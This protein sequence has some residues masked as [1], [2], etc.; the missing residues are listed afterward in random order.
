RRIHVALRRET[1]VTIARTGPYDPQSI[2][3]QGPLCLQGVD[4]PPTHST[5]II[6]VPTDPLYDITLIRMGTALALVIETT[7]GQIMRWIEPHL[8]QEIVREYAGLH[9]APTPQGDPLA[10]E[11]LDRANT[12]ASMGDKMRREVD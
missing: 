1:A 5:G 7:D 10:L 2:W 9:R 3:R 8:L 4:G 6:L 12:R 11:I